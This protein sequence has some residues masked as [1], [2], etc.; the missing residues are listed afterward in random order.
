MI[1]TVILKQVIWFDQIYANFLKI[2]LAKIIKKSFILNNFLVLKTLKKRVTTVLFF[3][4]QHSLT[5]Y[6]QLIDIAAEDTPKHKNR[7]RVTYILSSLIYNAKLF[8][9]V[10]TDELTYLPTVTILYESAGWL[11]REVWDLFGIYFR[12]NKDLRR[13]LTDYGFSGHPLRKDFPMSGF[14]EVYYS[15]DKK[16]IVTVPVV[17]MQEYRIFTL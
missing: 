1:T 4:K 7:F 9:T 6:K 16:K 5:L 10:V 8:V 13:I 11:E 12:G 2:L 3:V 14:N 17:F 15:L